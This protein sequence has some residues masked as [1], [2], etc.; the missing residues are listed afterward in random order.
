MELDPGHVEL[1]YPPHL[2]QDRGSWRCHHLKLCKTSRNYRPRAIQSS[3][4]SHL[5]CYHYQCCKEGAG[6]YYSIGP[7]WILFV[8]CQLE[9]RF[10]LT[11][12]WTSG[13]CQTC[14]KRCLS[15]FVLGF[16]LRR[17]F[18]SQYK[19]LTISHLRCLAWGHTVK[20]KDHSEFGWLS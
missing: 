15:S 2:Q 18:E 16:G 19:L 8:L 17:S 12:Q 5:V 7:K 4:S 14:S 10:L 3:K 11:F 20:R 6:K 1:S 13:S 9:G